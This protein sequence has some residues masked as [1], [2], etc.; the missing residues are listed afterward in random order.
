M[1]KQ[2][3]ALVAYLVFKASSLA[4]VVVHAASY[5]EAKRLA[6]A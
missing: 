3:I 6:G 5:A 2:Q 1:K 4:F